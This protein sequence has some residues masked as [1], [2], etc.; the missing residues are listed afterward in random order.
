ML[1]AVG[2]TTV[3]LDPQ[4]GNL[5]VDPNAVGDGGEDEGGAIFG[6]GRHLRNKYE[7]LKRKAARRGIQID[8]DDDGAPEEKPI[9][10]LYQ[11]AVALGVVTENQFEGLGFA[12]IAA[13]TAGFIQDTVNRNLWGKG[14]VLDSDDAPS[15]TVT[16]I[17]VAGLPINV[18]AAGAP[19]SMFQHD[20]TRFGITFGRRIAL[21]GQVIR[22]DA[23]NNDSS[24]HSLS[25]A[26][27]ADEMNPYMQQ[28]LW[29]RLLVQAAV[30]AFGGQ[31]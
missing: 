17:T 22:V 14:I 8:D 23:F 10:D 12:S 3:F 25:G 19:L 9:Q 29:E 15:M 1:Q 11:H 27:V 5:L 2:Q 31:G 21:V 30:E 24:A 6:G 7:R 16:A 4:S 13:T 28:A 20:S 26:V 18:G